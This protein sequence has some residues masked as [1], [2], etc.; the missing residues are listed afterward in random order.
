[1]TIKIIQAQIAGYTAH[2]TDIDLYMTDFVSAAEA[3][4]WAERRLQIEGVLID[5]RSQRVSFFDGLDLTTEQV[6][7]LE[8]PRSWQD[9]V[10]YT[11]AEVDALAADSIGSF[12]TASD[13]EA[14]AAAGVRGSK[15]ML[16]EDFD[17]TVNDPRLGTVAAE[18]YKN[19]VN[20]IPF[21]RGTWVIF[22]PRTGSL[23]DTAAPEPE[24]E[25]DYIEIMRG[26]VTYRD[27]LEPE[28][29][30]LMLDDIYEEYDETSDERKTRISAAVKS[31][32]EAIVA[33]NVA[34]QAGYRVKSSD[35]IMDGVSFDIPDDEYLACRRQ[36]SGYLATASS[37][38]WLWL[39][40]AE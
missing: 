25:P 15:Y 17:G 20:Y 10:Y 33:G 26:V 13:D 37:H 40:K 30:E 36:F 12:V 9:K 14:I 23:A 6:A 16:P 2:I 32:N 5:A 35:R 8:L 18:Y 1:M 4:F 31:L 28:S 21:W 22:V 19:G 38:R 27:S 3:Q 29:H 34:Y 7:I 24:S 39:I 11:R